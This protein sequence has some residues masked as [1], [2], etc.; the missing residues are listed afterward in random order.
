MRN[1]FI[2]LKHEFLTTIR[3]PSFWVT[4]FLLPGM[5]ILLNIGTQVVSQDAFS[6]EDQLIP[7]TDLSAQA[8][9][10]T[11]PQVIGYVDEA[12]ILTQ[13]PPSLPAGL[14]QAYATETAANDALNAGEISQ[15]YLIPADFLQEHNVLLVSQE[16][17]PFNVGSED[18]F[19]YVIAYGL[20]GDE[21]EA[22]VYTN[23]TFSVYS[24]DVAP[25]ELSNGNDN[26][27][28]LTFFVPYA[29]MFIFFFLITMSSG[30]MLQSV[31]REKENR[32]AEVL[33]LSLRPRELMLGKVLGLSMVALLQML[34]WF[35]GGMIALDRVQQ[36]LD[37]LS[38]FTLPAG[39]IVWGIGFFVLGYLLY[40]SVMGAVG[41]LAPNAREGGQFTFV[42]LLPLMIPLWLNY[43]FIESPNG[44]LATALSLIPF[45]APV[46]MMT[47]M[48]ATT[49]PV[50]QIL[51]SLGGLALT[52]YVLVLIAARFFRA[53]TL[54]SDASF[55]WKRIFTE[56]RRA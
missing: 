29:V 42:I 6:N 49:V 8:E 28:P 2:V 25:Q 27:S 18:F 12:D 24:H 31:T 1:I 3:K 51:V 40:A 46:S 7:G 23:P 10:I 21:M 36:M 44:T 30:F 52:T 43:V 37:M 34:F 19:N 33:L 5:I 47:R 45:T 20:T 56:L 22:A 39:F 26:G 15:Y 35:G 11:H 54:L 50:W 48:V 38:T 16:F 13:L 17:S 53:D 4:T 14:L 9:N 41:A 32:T 55:H